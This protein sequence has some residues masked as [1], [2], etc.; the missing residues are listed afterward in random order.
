MNTETLAL[1][2]II[3]S[4]SLGFIGLILFLIN[5]RGHADRVQAMALALISPLIVP[6]A[7][8]ILVTLGPLFLLTKTQKVL[9]E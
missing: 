9:P 3:I 5:H 4:Y 6:A 8:I 1:Y 2:F 7:F